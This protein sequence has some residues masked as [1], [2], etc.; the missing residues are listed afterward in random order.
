MLHKYITI[1]TKCLVCLWNKYML[2]HLVDLDHINMKHGW[3]T[4]QKSFWG[5]HVGGGVYL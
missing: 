4:P 1:L 3:N 5:T 2:K